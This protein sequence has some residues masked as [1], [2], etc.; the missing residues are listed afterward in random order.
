MARF[1]KC[2]AVECRRNDMGDCTI[3]SVTISSEGNCVDFDPWL[4]G[5][6]EKSA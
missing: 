2:E 3:V 4:E 1:S 5:E 6:K